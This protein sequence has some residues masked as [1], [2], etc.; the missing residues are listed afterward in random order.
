MAK[1]RKF[2]GNLTSGGE[3][4]GAKAGIAWRVR[5][6]ERGSCVLSERTNRREEVQS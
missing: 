1:D 2:G 6:S 4:S 5:E 3:N